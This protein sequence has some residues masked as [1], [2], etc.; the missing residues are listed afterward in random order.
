MVTA[1]QLTPG[2]K[3]LSTCSNASRSPSPEA[4]ECSHNRRPGASILVKAQRNR[5]LEL[6]GGRPQHSGGDARSELLLWRSLH[7]GEVQ[8]GHGTHRLHHSLG[9]SGQAGKRLPN[10]DPLGWH[11]FHD[12]KEAVPPDVE[13]W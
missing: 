11:F 12:P 4:Q 5:S 7:A 9:S 2:V 8:N 1:M 6:S 3:N 13:R 10:C